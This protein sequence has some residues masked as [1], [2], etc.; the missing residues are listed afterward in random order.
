MILVLHNTEQNRY[1]LDEII[2]PR[3]KS[4]FL[5]NK[6]K[7]IIKSIIILYIVK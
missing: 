7:F 2:I 3:R 6:I 4:A 1:D 5:L